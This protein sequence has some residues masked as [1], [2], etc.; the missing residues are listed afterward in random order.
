MV[1]YTYCTKRTIPVMVSVFPVPGGPWISV[2]LLLEKHG[3]RDSWPASLKLKYMPK[4]PEGDEGTT[5]E[6][7]CLRGCTAVGAVFV[8]GGRRVRVTISNITS[9]RPRQ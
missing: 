2:I 7:G 5:R 4:L 3:L 8:H 1:S 9:T 6:T